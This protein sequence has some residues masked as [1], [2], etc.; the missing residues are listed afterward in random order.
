[1]TQN[2]GESVLIKRLG[3]LRNDLA[4]SEPEAADIVDSAMDIIF[5][6]EL[7]VKENR[8]LHEKYEI[9]AKPVKGDSG[10][11][12][13]PVCHRKLYSTNNHCGR[14]GKRIDWLL[15]ER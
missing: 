10:F 14:C 13:C 11:Y 3:E 8:M 15:E 9:P 12:I 7:T 4:E 5:D 1:M 2:P 6:Y